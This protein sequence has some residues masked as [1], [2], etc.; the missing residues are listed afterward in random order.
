[1]TAGGP[2]ADVATERDQAYQALRAAMPPANMQAAL[3]CSVKLQDTLPHQGQ[4]DRNL[5]M[6][7][8]GGGKDSSYTLAFVRAMQLI[9]FRVYGSTFRLRVATNRHAGMPRAV[10]ENVDREYQALRLTADPDCELL[11][12]DGSEVSVFDVNTP[13]REHVIRRNRLDTLMT[14]HRTFADGRPTFCNACN[15]SVV[16]SFGLGAAYGDGADLIITGDSQQE[17]REYAVWVSR[18]ARRLA[19]GSRGSKGNGLGGLLSHVDQI[20][21]SYFTDIYGEDAVETI[22]ER[23]VTSQVPERL[24]FFSIYSDTAYTARDH[25]DLLT[26]LLGFKFDDVAFSFTESDCGNPTLMAHLRG[27]KCERVFQRSYA[28]GLAEYVKFALGLM[29]K[30]DFPPELIEQMRRR[31]AGPDAADQMRQVAGRYALETFGLTEEQLICMVYSPFAD[32][33]AG[34]EGFLAREHPSLAA[35]VAEVH[36]V[37]AGDPGSVGGPGPLGGPPA[38]AAGLERISG[39]ELKQ[40]RVL[41]R[42]PMRQLDGRGGTEVIDAVL[43]GDPHKAV[44]HTRHAPDGPDTLEQISGR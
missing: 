1:M 21:Q 43:A 28:E 29:R 2:A 30:K 17:Q 39:L 44:I 18:L 16:N 37:L 41:Y 34:L 31:Y 40:L 5:V 42:S 8:Y 13:Q 32:E 33:G 10:L 4:L 12:I 14:G 26:G 15:L 7:A 27:L 25:L 6:V 19:P 11:L 36:A 9:L 24:R 20:S 22:A 35:R 3:R 38:L 23:R